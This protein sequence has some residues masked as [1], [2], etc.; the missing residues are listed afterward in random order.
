MTR[1]QHAATAAA[2]LRAAIPTGHVVGTLTAA[3]RSRP[4][5]MRSRS[6]RLRWVV[7]RDSLHNNVTRPSRRSD[8]AE[9]ERTLAAK[10]TEPSCKH[11]GARI[12]APLSQNQQP[13]ASIP[14]RPRD[15]ESSIDQAIEQLDEAPAVFKPNPILPPGSRPLLATRCCQLCLA[16]ANQLEGEAQSRREMH[17]ELMHLRHQCVKFRDRVLALESELAALTCL[18][19]SLL[20]VSVSDSRPASTEPFFGSPGDL[21]DADTTN[22][23]SEVKA[24]PERNDEHP[25]NLLRQE[26]SWFRPAT[27]VSRARTSA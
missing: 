6:E 1:L 9:Y 8:D 11:A 16:A 5:Q 25:N 17:L 18:P 3:G 13:L 24:S 23:F 4:P 12:A 27:R 7:K 10:Q 15:E 20:G 21:G 2:T 26:E 14:I 22:A 19:P